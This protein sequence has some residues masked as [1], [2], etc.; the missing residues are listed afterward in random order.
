MH[1]A[2]R[3]KD[4]TFVEHGVGK[5]SAPG[6]D[7]AAT[8]NARSSMDHALGPYFDIVI[9]ECHSVNSDIASELSRGF[10][11]GAVM[12][13]NWCRGELWAEVLDDR[14]K[15]AVDIGDLD[16]GEIRH[17]DAQ[18]H[19][20]GNGLAAGET[21]DLVGFI[22]ERDLSG[23]GTF[24]CCRAGDYTHSITDELPVDQCCQVCQANC[25]GPPRVVFCSVM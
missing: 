21:D 11:N 24:E 10:D 15:R 9:D 8:E 14:G 2:T 3:A 22:D 12:D 19:K 4:C 16:R 20:H 5:D 6:T 17:L 25:H 18:G 13:S 23:L 1:D 7:L